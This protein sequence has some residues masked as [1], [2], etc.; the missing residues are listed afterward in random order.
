[1]FW[2]HSHCV[3]KPVHRLVFIRALSL[4]NRS[5][6]VQ[7]F[8]HSLTRDCWFPPIMRGHWK[9]VG[10]ETKLL[11][12]IWKNDFMIPCSRQVF[13]LHLKLL[14]QIF[15][16]NNFFFIISNLTSKRTKKNTH[17][18]K[19]GA[20]ER[21]RKPYTFASIH[22][23]EYHTINLF[24]RTF[25]L[26][27]V[28]VQ[29]GSHSSLRTFCAILLGINANSNFFSLFHLVGK[30]CCAAASLFILSYL[31]FRNRCLQFNYVK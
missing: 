27:L 1:M 26:F 23:F 5:L 30:K 10:W 11:Y 16:L 9:W 13:L 28:P 3:G 17:T 7:T 8:T 20:R 21:G 25:F 15:A 31:S 14:P 19:R 29:N 22:M 6:F 18:Q 4:N 12:I 24:A 2:P